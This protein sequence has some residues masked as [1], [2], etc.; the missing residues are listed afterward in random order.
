SF[1]NSS[2]SLRQERFTGTIPI[3]GIEK[4]LRILMYTTP[5]TYTWNQGA[6]VLR[7]Q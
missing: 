6:I 3:G 2:K 5:F 4:T 7:E 1:D